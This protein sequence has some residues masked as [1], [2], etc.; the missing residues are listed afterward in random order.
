[1]NA[2]SCPEEAKIQ[3][4]VRLVLT[5]EGASCLAR[6]ENS[7]KRGRTA[8]DRTLISLQAFNPQTVQ[9]L[10][11]NRYLDSAETSLQ[12]RQLGQRRK[13]LMD[14]T[15]L[16]TH[17]FLYRQFDLRT[18]GALLGSPLIKQWNRGNPRNPID[19]RT[20]LS[21]QH[22]A[23]AMQQLL[24]HV[25]PL[26]QQVA[27]L[28]ERRIG[29]SAQ[30]D[31]RDKALLLATGHRLLAGL[32][33]V[34]WVVLAAHRRSAAC[35]EFL[36][37]IADGVGAYL[38]K[39][40]VAEYLSLMLVELLVFLQ[41]AP[42]P[43]LAGSAAQ[44]RIIYQLGPRLQLPDQAG[45]LQITLLHSLTEAD[46]LNRQI[47][48][49]AGVRVKQKSLKDFFHEKTTPHCR[50]HLGLYYLSYLKEASKNLGIRF[51]ST[52]GQVGRGERTLIHLLLAI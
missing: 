52:V 29:Q 4:P 47:S 6:V 40:A 38:E 21:G 39:S 17:G 34:I 44:L 35:A 15:R 7:L 26:Q 16:V 50:E 9:R 5:E 23:K 31:E 46:E 8:R 37:S 3:L 28:V 2:A 11:Q 20:P 13:N 19:A 24:P 42:A 48:E 25:H 12:L 32:S 30:V 45:K 14:L 33:P 27:Q 18:F 36:Q 51:S 43:R 41:T 1:M 22:L 10:I 49:K